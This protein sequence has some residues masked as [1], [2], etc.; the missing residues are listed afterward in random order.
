MEE[1]SDVDD[2]ILVTVFLSAWSF[3]S[4]AVEESSYD[5][6]PSAATLRLHLYPHWYGRAGL[7]LVEEAAVVVDGLW[8]L[9]SWPSTAGQRLE[10]SGSDGWASENIIV[11]TSVLSADE[12]RSVVAA[13]LQGGC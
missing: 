11:P 1:E 8:C 7:Q 5:D 4:W 10:E 3:T 6:Q 9:L 12:T 2:Q 13:G